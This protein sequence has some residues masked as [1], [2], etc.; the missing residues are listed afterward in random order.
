MPESSQYRSESAQY[1]QR[2]PVYSDINQPKGLNKGD[3][4]KYSLLAVTLIATLASGVLAQEQAAQPAAQPAKKE[5][6]QM[7]P[8][9]REA[10]I[11]KRLEVIKAKDEAQYKELVALKEKDPKAFAAK[12]RE[13]GPKRGAGGEHKKGKNKAQ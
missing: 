1:F 2:C 3:I 8:E 13:L 9:Q 11:N 7:T 6:K 4:M 10:M 12:M 5:H